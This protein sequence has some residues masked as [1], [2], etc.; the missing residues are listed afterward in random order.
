MLKSIASGILLVVALVGA[1]EV[2]SEEVKSFT[3]A[4]FVANCHKSAGGTPYAF[5]GLEVDKYLDFNRQRLALCVIDKPFPPILAREAI[6]YL[7]SHRDLMDK[8]QDELF[9]KYLSDKFKCN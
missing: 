4:A 2:R 6:D 5:C 7:Y 1:A 9:E 3:S 8:D